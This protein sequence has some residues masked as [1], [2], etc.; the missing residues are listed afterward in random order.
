MKSALNANDN[1]MVKLKAE[2]A[3][4]FRLLR[5]FVA[6]GLGIAGGIGSITSL[7]KL[8]QGLGHQTSPATVENLAI[9]VAG[10]VSAIIYLRWEDIKNKKTIA[11]FDLKQA[12]Q[13][14]RPTQGGLS[15]R[16]Q[17]LALLPVGIQVSNIDETVTRTV[18][19]RDLQAQ[20]KQSVVILAGAREFLSDA[21]LAARLVREVE[22]AENNVMV[23]PFCSD[24][25]D[26]SKGSAQALPSTEKDSVT[27]PAYF[28]T[29]QQVHSLLSHL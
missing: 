19:L 13:E 17:A 3:T 7:T 23:I 14:S 11:K 28:A 25:A 5:V 16:D 15:A 10:V 27:R 8:L 1:A 22:F 18:P 9:N 4:P 6:S 21:T 24:Q 12:A 29:P 2:A 26:I 20:G